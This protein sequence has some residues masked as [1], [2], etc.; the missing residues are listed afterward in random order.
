MASVT[1]VNLESRIDALEHT[2]YEREKQIIVLRRKVQKLIG[3]IHALIFI[4]SIS[5]TFEWGGGHG[6]Q[7]RKTF[8]NTYMYS[9]LCHESSV[10]EYPS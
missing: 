7:T 10:E 1:R 4:I 3:A 8:V 6:E 2:L 9:T 5:H